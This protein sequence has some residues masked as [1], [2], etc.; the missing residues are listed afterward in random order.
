M[1]RV[2]YSQVNDSDTCQSYPEYIDI[3]GASVAKSQS[4]NPPVS[5]TTGRVAY[6]NGSQVRVGWFQLNHWMVF[7]GFWVNLSK[8]VCLKMELYTKIT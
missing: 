8:R 2:S 5:W 3:S 1:N 6:L 7:G 4:F